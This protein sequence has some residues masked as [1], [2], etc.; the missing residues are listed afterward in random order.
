M[1][2]ADSPSSAYCIL[3]CDQ[4]AASKG[5]GAGHGSAEARSEA[6]PDAGIEVESDPSKQPGCPLSEPLTGS[7]QAGQLSGPMAAVTREVSGVLSLT[8]QSRDASRDAPGEQ[9]GALT[10]KTSGNGLQE[11]APVQLGQSSGYGTLM[12]CEPDPMEDG[13]E[14]KVEPAG[15]RDGIR[16]SE[17]P[18]RG[19]SN[20]PSRGPGTACKEQ[21]G[22]CG[23][24][25]EHPKPSI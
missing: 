13:Q 20:L 15:D 14:T 22:N 9:T 2:A 10:G 11:G 3:E 25:Y 24:L 21:Q 1:G 12:V 17:Q 23:P 16:H 7:P 18:T 8:K 6:Y 19:R 5:L 4:E